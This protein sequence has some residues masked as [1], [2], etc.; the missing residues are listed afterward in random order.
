M[1]SASRRYYTPLLGFLL[2]ACIVRFW[3]FLL[4]ES[5]WLDETVT[6]FVIR[7]GAN[8]A[9]LAAGPKLDQT[10]YYWLPRI[11]QALLGYSE[12]SL[13]LPSVLLTLMSLLLIGRLAARL[14]HPQAGWVAIFLCFIPHEFTRQATDARPYGAGT[15][16]ALCAIWFLIRWLD[17]DEMK[18]AAGFAV[19]AVLLLHIHLIYWPFYAIF[20]GYALTRRIRDET[21]VSRGA[22]AAVFAIVTASLVPL[23]SPTMSLFRHAGAHVVTELPSRTDIVGGFQIS[24]IAAAAIGPWLAGKIFHWRADPVRI[25]FSGMILLLTW[26]LWVPVCLLAFSWITGN[27]VFLPRYFSLAIPGM[28][29]MGTLAAACSIPSG[30]WK[31]AA[32]AVAFGI[33]AIGFWKQPFPPSRNSHWREAA[34]A[35]NDL[36]G[37]SSTPVI[38]PSPFI[39]AQPPVWTSAYALPGFLY[40]HLSAY[41]INGPTILLPA[42]RSPEGE[43]YAELMITKRIAP[44]GRF[45]VYGGRYSVN[46]W[47]EWFAQQPE[48]KGWSHRETG[49]FGDVEVVPFQRG[50]S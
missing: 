8:H 22:L 41:P 29:L 4:P 43:Q 18:Y 34:W 44:S 12:F 20:G 26:W 28:I 27:S 6:A 5:F 49:S 50:N 21:A 17:R 19:C 10:I 13:R 25:T 11:S 48:L 16:V 42:R 30:A 40:A 37:N 24:M 23:I 36:V 35:V 33:L 2:L 9:S 7:H 31:P 14:I 3:L 47:V 46:F 45:I 38:C 1:K 39:E 32:V 15:C